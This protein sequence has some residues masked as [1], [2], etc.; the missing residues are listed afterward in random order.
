MS[1]RGELP[2]LSK[3]KCTNKCVAAYLTSS[4]AGAQG[5]YG[6]MMGEDIR[7]R[8]TG[9]DRSDGFRGALAHCEAGKLV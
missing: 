3:G 5:V 6:G 8:Y 2:V 4:M 7:K 1:A 9:P